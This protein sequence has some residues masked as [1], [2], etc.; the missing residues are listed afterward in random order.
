[1]AYKGRNMWEEHHRITNGYLCVCVQF[2]AL[3]IAYPF[4]NL[5]YCAYGEMGNAYGS[6]QLESNL[7]ANAKEGV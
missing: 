2:F 6:Q 7:L 1:M 4:V 5:L 3:N